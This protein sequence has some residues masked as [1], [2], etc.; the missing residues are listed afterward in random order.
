M[1]RLLPF[2]TEFRQFA[3]DDPKTL[4]CFYNK[5]PDSA[6]HIFNTYVIKS[7]Q[8]ANTN[9]NLIS[10]LHFCFFPEPKIIFPPIISCRFDLNTTPVHLYISLVK[11][12]RITMLPKWKLLESPL[13]P[14]W[15]GSEYV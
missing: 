8:Y 14:K 12:T 6:V 1:Q 5:C 3:R 4:C 7:N 9:K 11:S 13:D 15:P 2:H 10:K